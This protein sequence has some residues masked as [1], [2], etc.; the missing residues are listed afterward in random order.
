MTPPAP[1]AVQDLRPSLAEAGFN[2]AD[3]PWIPFPR[4]AEMSLRETLVEAAALPGWPSGEPLFTAALLRLLTA[5]VYRIARITDTDSLQKA[6]AREALF[7]TE[8]VNGYFDSHRDEFWVL[9]PAGSSH[10]PFYQDPALAGETAVPITRSRVAM[11]VLASYVWGQQHP[12]PAF[13]PAAAARSLLVFLLY[14][15]G[16]SGG[17]HPDLPGTKWQVGR[18][19]GMVSIH[20]TGPRLRDT[21]NLHLIDPDDTADTLPGGIGRP[22]WEAPP[23]AVTEAITS[24]KTIME[25]LTSRWEKTALLVAAD[26]GTTIDRAVTVSGRRRGELP[27]HDP[28]TVRW[29][30]PPEDIKKAKGKTLPLYKYLRGR[31]GRAPW[32]DIDNYRAQRD[33]NATAVVGSVADLILADVTVHAWVT[34]SHQPDNAKDVMWAVSAIPPDALLDPVAG[35]RAAAFIKDAETID[36]KLASALNSFHKDAGTDFAG[37]AKRVRMA[38]YWSHME[39]LFPRAVAVSHDRMDIR[40]AA[41]EVYDQAVASVGD[42]MAAPGRSKKAPSEM[43]LEPIAVTAARHRPTI[44]FPSSKPKNPTKEPT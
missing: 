28:Y 20:P 7:D 11:D 8:A 13:T 31:A 41:R 22:S 43:R 42:R 15:P 23:L 2:L 4:R 10:R 36:K 25:Q 40:S 24:P 26:N 18:L 34:V 19:R 6:R 1:V 12:D 39:R 35:N 37:T 32:R 17:S 38:S 21:L 9:P 30:T 29:D 27:E 16:G 14:G 5:L 44:N 3:D 33:S